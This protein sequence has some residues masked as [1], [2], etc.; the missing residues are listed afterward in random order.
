[1]PIL[2]QNTIYQ[3]LLTSLGKLVDPNHFGFITIVADS[4]YQTI[5][6]ATWLQSMVKTDGAARSQE[7]QKGCFRLR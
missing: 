7:I 1:M 4:P 5:S 2:S 3:D 6:S